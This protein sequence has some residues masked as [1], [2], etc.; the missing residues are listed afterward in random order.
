MG[1]A[2]IGITIGFGGALAVTRVL[3]ALLFG[4]ASSDPV[5]FASVATLL[6]LVA[7]AASYLPARRAARIAPME[8]LRHQ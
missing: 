6:T 7:L 5:T 3:Q 4:V 8:A 1:L 2:G